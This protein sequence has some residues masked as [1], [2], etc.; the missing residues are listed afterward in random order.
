[1]GL[2]A[3]AALGQIDP[4]HRELIQL[5]Y[6]QALVG[7]SPISGYAFY[8]DNEPGFLRTN[9][10]LRLAVAPVY[11]DSELGFRNALGPNTDLGLGVAGGGYANSYF[12]MR[13]GHFIREESFTGHGAEISGSVYHLFNPGMLIPL[14]GVF[15]VSPR[16]MVYDRDDTTAPSFVVPDDRAGLNTRIG[17]RFGGV[18]PLIAPELA[19]EVSAWYENQLREDSET[20]GY[21]D[22]AIEPMSQFF[23]A[24]T[25]FIYTFK[26]TKQSASM[27]L[28]AGSSAGAD[29]LSAY[30][31]GGDLPLSSEFPLIL[32][33]YYY[34]EISARRFV[35]FT[36]QYTLPI[37]PSKR[38]AL[39]AI[40]SVA[41]VEYLPDLE[42][43]GRLHSGA[44]LGLNYRSP[45]G[46]F[47]LLAGY[48]Y[49]F[50]AI[51]SDGNRGQSIGILCQIDLEA[52]HK[53][54]I[55]YN[56]SAPSQ[57]TGLFHYLG[58]MF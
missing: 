32:P 15:R 51:R 37:T 30:R 20:Y 22:R 43:P 42:Q 47:T 4:D 11:L 23:W 21:G 17:L 34:Q 2:A 1:L 35:N 52:Y 14:T 49:G 12:E 56:Q 55:K 41:D 6:N 31:L 40:G 24:R 19:L 8:Y 9:I 10:T 58:K 16:Y 5:G 28:T 39:S 7:R 33:G 57:S 53:S 3:S 54:G 50:Q 25:L 13:G 44:G 29:R 27:S 45:S 46:S 18:E 48:C 36:A 26:E 38:W